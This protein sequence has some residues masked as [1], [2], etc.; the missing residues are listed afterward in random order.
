MSIQQPLLM[1]T[2]ATGAGLALAALLLPVPRAGGESMVTAQTEIQRQMQLDCQMVTA[3]FADLMTNAAPE[4]AINAFQQ[5]LAAA[6]E[7]LTA[8]NPRIGGLLNSAEDITTYLG[9]LQQT[10]D[11]TLARKEIERLTALL[12]QKR[13]EIERLRGKVLVIGTFFGELN[14]KT[15]G[16]LDIYKMTREMLGEEPALK[17]MRDVISEDLAAWRR[18]PEVGELNTWPAEIGQ[19]ESPPPTTPPPYS[20]G[21]IAPPSYWENERQAGVAG[22]EL[23]RW[24]ESIARRTEYRLYILSSAANPTGELAALNRELA[25]SV[26]ATGENK[27]YQSVVNLLTADLDGQEAK[28]RQNMAAAGGALKDS[29][30]A[31]LD[32]LTRRRANLKALTDQYQIVSRQLAAVQRE[33]RTLERLSGVA[34]AIEGPLGPATVIRES[35]ANTRQ[36]WRQNMRLAGLPI[37]AAT[38]AA[39]KEMA[40]AEAKPLIIQPEL[41]TMPAQTGAGAIK[42]GPGGATPVVVTPPPPPRRNFGALFPD[43]DGPTQPDWS[44]VPLDHLGAGSRDAQ[45]RQLQYSKANDLPIEVQTRKS[46]IFLRLVPPGEFIMGSS[47]E[48][49]GDSDEK[50]HKVIISRPM[51]IG[52]YEITQGQWTKVMGSNPAYFKRSK[53]FAPVENVS[54]NDCQAFLNRLATMEGVPEGTYRLPTE[55]EW[56]YACRAGTQ[57]PFCYGNQASMRNMNCQGR[58]GGALTGPEMDSTISVGAFQ[59]NAWGLY[60]MHGNVWEWVA[61]GYA[62]QY[63]DGPVTDPV[64]PNNN[65]RAVR[66][67]AW[68]YS[69][70]RC[71]SAE[72][73]PQRITEREENIGLRLVRNIPDLDSK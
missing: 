31:L 52:K 26:D 4:P 63:P 16:W 61:D 41:A 19:R 68:N 53:E 40:E 66:G 46:G 69:A 43:L 58:Y 13:A 55:A 22:A 2:L 21:A 15:S 28:I 73:Y 72:R 70:Y 18:L 5:D 23:R 34:T 29:Y 12:N 14:Q 35:A 49:D 48:E 7:R 33:L 3:H 24:L 10:A 9:Q 54:W 25:R 56:E 17:N 57:T 39:A 20:D 8:I 36:D 71:R 30:N 42:T 32:E 60:D 37:L 62:A 51:Y 44:R 1:R 47:R 27:K 45:E 6:M 59:P 67:G 50:P 65:L 11:N 38:Q 64:G